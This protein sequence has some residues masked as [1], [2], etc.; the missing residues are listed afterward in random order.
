MSSGDLIF[1]YYPY[2]VSARS[3]THESIVRPVSAIVRDWR[4]AQ[5]RADSAAGRFGGAVS[6]SD[7]NVAGP[8]RTRAAE[9]GKRKVEAKGY[10]HEQQ[11]AALDAAE[12]RAVRGLRPAGVDLAK[13]AEELSED[14]RVMDDERVRLIFPLRGPLFCDEG[15]YGPARGRKGWGGVGL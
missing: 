9:K 11:A 2:P 14:E 3:K 13:E 10:T 6:G 4:A 1:S 8:S 7:D 12:R 15:P 5:A